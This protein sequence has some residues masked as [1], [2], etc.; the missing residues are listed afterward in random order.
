MKN[1]VE[2]NETDELASGLARG[3]LDKEDHSKH[4]Y[5]AVVYRNE[6]GSLGVSE[7]FTNGKEAAAPLGLAIRSVG[8]PSKVLGVIHNHPSAIVES[9]DDYLKEESYAINKLPSNNDWRTAKMLFSDRVDVTYYLLGP[10][11]VLRKY[12]YDDREAWDKKNEHNYWERHQRRYEVGTELEI[13]DTEVPSDGE[14]DQ[15]QVDPGSI[16]GA[17]KSVVPFDDPYL[18]RAFAALLAGNGSEMD[19]IAGEFARSPEGQRMAQWGDQLF[20]Q[21]QALEQ[22]RIEQQR[23][24]QQ[25]MQRQGPVMG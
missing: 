4:E 3:I 8:G 10:D 1:V 13:P 23:Q 22:Q 11:S 24:E 2:R 16:H 14:R 20:A 25:Q 17:S 18:D 9:V 12:E 7:L 5:V 21:Q 15:E 19:R 6:D